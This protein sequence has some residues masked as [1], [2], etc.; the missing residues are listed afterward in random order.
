[1]FAPD[2]QPRTPD[3][4]PAALPADRVVPPELAPPGLP[5][6]RITLPAPAEGPG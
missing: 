5:L 4:Q 3:G 1:M 6:R 2:F